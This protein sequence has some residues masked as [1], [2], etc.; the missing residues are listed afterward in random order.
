[1]KN[2]IANLWLLGI[3]ITFIA[4]F[5][6]YIAITLNYSAS[7]KMKNEILTII[8]KHKGL[9]NYAGEDKE[10]IID[11]KGT[12]RTNVG[13]FQTINLFLLGNAYTAKGY[14]PSGT[15]FPGTWYGV[16]DLG[17]VSSI[18]SGTINFELANSGKKYHYCFAKYN[19][20]MKNGQYKSV[21]YRVRLFYKFEIPVL[22][23]F[24][25]IKVDGLTDEIYDPQDEDGS[26]SISS[27]NYY[28]V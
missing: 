24:L 23:D 25:S 22:S 20:N 7:F 16:E 14:C 13:A 4:L 9:T 17:S 3:I 27:S 21:Y 2:G 8:E 19:A 15:D 11:G 28:D 18:K 6:A 5:S 12:V 1:M 26:I 10:S